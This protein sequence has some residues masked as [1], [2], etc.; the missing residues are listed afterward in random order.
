MKKLRF[1]PLKHVLFTLFVSCSNLQNKELST[2]NPYKVRSIATTEEIAKNCRELVH[3]A[4]SAPRL[5]TKQRLAKLKEYRHSDDFEGFA[6]TIYNSYDNLHVGMND[7]PNGFS[8]RRES[9]T[10]TFMSWNNN[11]HIP[12][13]YQHYDKSGEDTFGVVTLV[14]QRSYDEGAQEQVEAFK[15]ARRWMD[16][17]KNHVG[18]PETDERRSFGKIGEITRR[19]FEAKLQ[20][21]ALQKF[22]FQKADFVRNKKQT[23]VIPY[24]VEV[25]GRPGEFEVVEIEK[26]FTS[27]SSYNR[28]MKDRALD[29][30]HIFTQD[31]MQEWLRKS[32]LYD[33]IINQAYRYR[34]IEIT[35]NV[36]A[37]IPEEFRNEEQKALLKELDHLLFDMPM[38]VRSDALKYVQEVERN[39][40]I[41]AFLTFKSSKRKARDRFKYKTVN[42]FV[43]SKTREVIRNARTWFLGFG[44]FSTVGT[45]VNTLT[46]PY[47]EDPEWKL[48]MAYLS[49]GVANILFDLTGVSIP[50]VSC[51]VAKRKW[52]VENICFD[53]MMEGHLLFYR[54]KH[55]IDPT[56]DY[57]NDKDYK[58]RRKRLTTKWLDRRDRFAAG[59]FFQDNHEFLVTE[60]YRAHVDHVLQ[61]LI[62]AQYSSSQL[63]EMVEDLF[64][65]A[66]Y[67]RE[68]EKVTNHLSQIRSLTNDDLADHLKRYIEME[69]TVIDRM[70][71]Y[72]TTPRKTQFKY[73]LDEIEDK[74]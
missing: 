16:E 42:N 56:Y 21:E 43:Q 25:E 72:G 49:N 11:D 1:A 24:I 59:E 55:T 27:Y 44:I 2:N 19:A 20:L 70:R 66:F 23:E 6:K 64:E 5:T 4:T 47:V 40:E 12:A 62:T 63:D 60:G 58:D 3:E 67:D 39:R 71:N 51:S 33:E 32:E 50:L 34:R 65:Y 7:I 10:K 28:Y 68:P 30:E 8:V 46:L 36:L 38:M 41:R 17:Y 61:E 13:Y 14:S 57:L 31:I 69:E 48:K 15:D 37:E 53:E 22:D 45:I 52:T 29:V 26:T 18:L 9:I 73:F 35:R 74:H 54:L